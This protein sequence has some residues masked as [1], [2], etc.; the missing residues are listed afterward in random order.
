MI[1]RFCRPR[2]TRAPVLRAARGLAYNAVSMN[3]AG[4]FI[5]LA[6]QLIDTAFLMI[7]IIG[8]SFFVEELMGVAASPIEEARQ[9]RVATLIV[10]PFVLAY[11]AFEVVAAASPGKLILRL[12]IANRDGTPAPRSRLVLRWTTKWM[13]TIFAFFEAA[14]AIPAFRFLYGVSSWVIIIGSVVVLRQSRLAWHDEWAGTSVVRL[15]RAEAA[16]FE[17]IMNVAA[18]GQG[19]GIDSGERIAGDDR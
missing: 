8:V 18:V 4:F 17:P 5:R 13:P 19:E 9:E 12:R 16:A 3:R 2:D 1:S 15:K 11:T 10:V 7:P 6:A 14:T